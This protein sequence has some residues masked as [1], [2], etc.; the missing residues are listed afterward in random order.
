MDKQYAVK[1]GEFQTMPKITPT[2]CRY[3]ARGS[4]SRAEACMFAHD[5]P[6]ASKSVAP[7]L[8]TDPKAPC[9]F[10]AR[11]KCTRSPC[12]FAHESSPT[13][14]APTAPLPVAQE[15]IPASQSQLRCKFFAKGHCRNGDT[16]RFAH[17]D[18]DATDRLAAPDETLLHVRYPMLSLGFYLTCWSIVE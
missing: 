6:D 16:C 4:C 10:F 15:P 8:G 17:S 12:P 7:G 3:Y 14:A 11:G 18:S 2:P 9:Q 13:P 5:G 1:V